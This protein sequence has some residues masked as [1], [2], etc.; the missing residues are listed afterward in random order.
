MQ[1]QFPSQPLP[2]IFKRFS[3]H[4]FYF[5]VV[6]FFVFIFGALYRP[7]G[8]DSLLD[9][10]KAS[11]SFNI[12]MIMCIVLLVMIASRMILYFTRVIRHLSMNW[13]RMW[14]IAEIVVCTFFVALYVTLIG[15]FEVQYLEI[16][17]GTAGYLALT[18]IFPYIFL[19]LAF[20][21]SAARKAATAAPEQTDRNIHFH[22]SSHNLKFVVSSDHILYIKADEN[23]ITVHYL[24]GESKK[25][26]ELRAS[27]KSIEDVCEKNGIIRC[28][29][30]YFINPAHVKAL[31]KDKENVIVAE[32][33][34]ADGTL[35]PVSKRYYE[36]LVKML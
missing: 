1:V 19:E 18:L 16:L 23:Y 14:C 8:L 13:Y 10:P 9:F 20:T 21:L 2:D 27:M 34:L 11:Y 35:I 36:D 33:D 30:S 24:E 6:P 31:R 25:T 7:F 26:Y 22:D 4:A 5:S 12:T 3:T 17:V 28:H 32:T 29:R 15:N